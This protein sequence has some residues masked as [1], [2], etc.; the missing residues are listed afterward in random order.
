MLTPKV[1]PKVPFSWARG[2]GKLTDHGKGVVYGLFLSGFSHQSIASLMSMTRQGV[3]KN[4]LST[5]VLLGLR[6]PPRAGSNLEANGTEV[7]ETDCL[8]PNQREIEERREL[9]DE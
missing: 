6:D 3:S 7:Q 5:E 8:S 1:D 4:I 9:I 2:Q